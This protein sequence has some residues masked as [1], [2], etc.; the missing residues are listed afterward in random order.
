MWYWKEYRLNRVPKW[1]YSTLKDC[2]PKKNQS[3]NKNSV[4]TISSIF[5]VVH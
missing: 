5:I 2:I 4:E 3:N 1:E